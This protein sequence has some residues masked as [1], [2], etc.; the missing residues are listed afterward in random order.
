MDDIHTYNDEEIT[1]INAQF[2]TYISKRDEY[3][4]SDQWKAH[5]SLGAILFGLIDQLPKINKT[6][7]DSR[8]LITN[9]TDKNVLLIKDTLLDD[10]IKSIKKSYYKNQATLTRL[11]LLMGDI[12]KELSELYPLTPHNK[13]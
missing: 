6:Y 5:K 9:I 2:D 13:P 7:R 1:K 12:R 8:Q 3:P 10:N 11:L 4:N